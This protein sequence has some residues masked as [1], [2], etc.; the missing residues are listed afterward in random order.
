MFYAVTP[1]LCVPAL[2]PCVLVVESE[3][4][5]RGAMLRMLTLAGFRTLAAAYEHLPFQPDAVLTDLTLPDGSGLDLIRRLRD[6]R[7]PVAVGV[8]TDGRTTAL[9]AAAALRPDAIFP[10][11]V[12][13]TRVIDWLTDPTAPRI[14]GA[15]T[16]VERSGRSA[17][18]SYDGL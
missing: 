6:R 16:P 18:R 13:L 15:C 4:L 8:V 7:E 1:R 17:G 12:D 5:A 3:P 11:P 14:R 2:A 10:R 9:N